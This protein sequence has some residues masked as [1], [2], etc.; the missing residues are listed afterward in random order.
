MPCRLPLS[1]I[2]SQIDSGYPARSARNRR[3][4][5]AK[6][7]GLG[8]DLVTAWCY[9]RGCPARHFPC[10]FP[11]EFLANFRRCP[12]EDDKCRTQREFS[13]YRFTIRSS[14][15]VFGSQ[16]VHP[17]HVAVDLPNTGPHKHL[18]P[19]EDECLLGV[20]PWSRHKVG[21]HMA[22]CETLTICTC[23][24]WTTYDRGSG[25]SDLA[26]SRHTSLTHPPPLLS[27]PVART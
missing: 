18:S 10:D 3:P 22:S 16:S 17:G 1:L 7:S 27:M 14:V 20:S 26:T 6:D 2:L 13:S 9:L 25:Q 5:Q 4:F 24:Q 23:R 8:A 21:D 19:S 12:R 11:G 15:R